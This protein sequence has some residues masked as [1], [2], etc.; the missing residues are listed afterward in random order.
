MRVPD[1]NKWDK[2]AL[3][4]VNATPWEFHKPS[5]LGIVFKDK[6][7]KDIDY[8]DNVS[9]SRQVYTIPSRER[10]R[11]DKRMPEVRSPAAARARL[12]WQ[13]PFAEM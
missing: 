13:S 9:L 12:D 2:E 1:A 8:K 5:D 10:L 4:K 7:E 6:A 11:I 3:S